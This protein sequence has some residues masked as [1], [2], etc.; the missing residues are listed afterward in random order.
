MQYELSGGVA[1]VKRDKV[2][3]L[4]SSSGSSSSSSA[5]SRKAPTTPTTPSKTTILA[6]HPTANF[7][8]LA[9]LEVRPGDKVC[10][11]GC[12]FGEGTK[13]IRASLSASNDAATVASGML[14]A[15]DVGQEACDKTAR[16]VAEDGARLQG[17]G[18]QP[19]LCPFTL[20]CAD[21]LDDADVV[22]APVGVDSEAR[23]WR[24]RSGQRNSFA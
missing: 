20:E 11:I 24:Q 21:V 1:H 7:R 6:V 16:V 2:D 12:S 8:R 10:E 3:L 9:R 18:L 15:L 14:L 17:A 23:P 4:F 5:E 13:V 22:A 19:H